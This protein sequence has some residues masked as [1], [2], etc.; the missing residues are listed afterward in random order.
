MHGRSTLFSH[1]P[2]CCPNT[3]S[4]RTAVNSSVREL[5]AQASEY[6]AQHQTLRLVEVP[7]GLP[8]TG[9]N[10]DGEDGA[11]AA[12]EPPPA[13]DCDLHGIVAD[14]GFECDQC[15]KLFRTRR[16]RDAHCR[17]SHGQIPA[18]TLPIRG[19]SCPACNSVYNTRGQAVTHLKTRRACLDFASQ[20]TVPLTEE[21]YR[22]E[23][24]EEKKRPPHDQRLVAPRVRP[25]CFYTPIVSFSNDCVRMKK[26]WKSM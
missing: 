25:Q 21:E 20:H 7:L 9:V 4:V 16:V 14:D 19:L 17:N 15:Q 5:G 11:G 22:L 6:L 2:V 24:A 18:H 23:L 3:E 26:S 13:P 8:R 12:A 1:L 10:V